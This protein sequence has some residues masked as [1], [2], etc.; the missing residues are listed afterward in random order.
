MVQNRGP[1]PATDVTITEVP[2]NLVLGTISGACSSFPCN[3]GGLSLNE[4]KSVTVQGT[5]QSGVTSFG[6]TVSVTSG[7]FDPDPANNT[8]T[9][10]TQVSLKA[11]SISKS[12]TPSSIIAGG[13]SVLTLALGNSNTTDLILSAQLIDSLPNGV[14]VSS[15]P[16]IGGTCPGNVIAVSAGSRVVYDAGSHIPPGGCT[17]SV[18][19]TAIDPGTYIN[20]IAE[21]DLQTNGGSNTS[22]ASASLSVSA[23]PTP[24]PTPTPPPPVPIPAMDR[25]SLL[26]LF[27]ALIFLAGSRYRAMRR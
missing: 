26:A 7:P 3:V 2:S 18:R 17:I 9:T 4:T 5:I 27:F 11:P 14:V 20:Q 19:L 8:A 23:A 21:G 25:E 10:N 13:S 16:G 6:N 15:T 1:D 24:T 22:P 12:F